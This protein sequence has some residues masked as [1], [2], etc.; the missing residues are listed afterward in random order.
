MSFSKVKSRVL[1][2]VVI[3]DPPDYC[4]LYKG[5]ILLLDLDRYHELHDRGL[6]DQA[7]SR[8]QAVKKKAKPESAS[9]SMSEREKKVIRPA[10]NK[11]LKK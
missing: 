2:N 6:V 4:E 11:G 7:E 1:K 3:V 5:D 9:K 8:S 10:E